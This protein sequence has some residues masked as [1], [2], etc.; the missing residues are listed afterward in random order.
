[1]GQRAELE[2]V[3]GAIRYSGRRDWVTGSIIFPHIPY[4][5]TFSA[6]RYE[7]SNDGQ[8][9]LCYIALLGLFV[10]YI[11]TKYQFVCKIQRAKYIL[12]FWHD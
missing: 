1:M 6:H 3:L 2:R 10:K 7:C 5:V 11:G 8:R 4:Y 12:D 9:A